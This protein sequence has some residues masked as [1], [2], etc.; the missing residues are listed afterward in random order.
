MREETG[1]QAGRPTHAWTIR[2]ADYQKDRQERHGYMA[3]V[4]HP[5]I[6]KWLASAPARRGFEK[7]TERQRASPTDRRT[8]QQTG[9]QTEVQ[10][11]RQ[12]GGRPDRDRDKGSDRK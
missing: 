7:G 4:V 3:R 6:I 10:A 11:G 1:A 12:T 9:G 8:D 5:E 2:Q